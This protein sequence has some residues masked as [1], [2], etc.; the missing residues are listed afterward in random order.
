LAPFNDTS[1][2]VVYGFVHIFVFFKY[3]VRKMDSQPPQEEGLSK[4][5]RSILHGI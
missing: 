1:G 3:F 2:D 5:S 4:I